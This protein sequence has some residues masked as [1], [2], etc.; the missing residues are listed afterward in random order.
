M[1]LKILITFYI[2]FVVALIAEVQSQVLNKDDTSIAWKEGYLDLHHINTGRGSVA[3]YIFPD[4]TTLLF[5]AGEQDP[6]DERTKSARN[7]IIR[8]NDKKRPFEWIA[9]YIKQVTPRNSNTVINYAILSHFHED[10]MGSWYE[11]A[12]KSSKGD[13]V[14]TGITGIAELLPIEVLLDRGYPSYNLPNDMKSSAFE[15]R[16]KANPGTLRYWKTMNNYFSFINYRE[17]QKLVNG[18][19]QAGSRTQV[20]LKYNRSRYRDF[21]VRNIKSNGRIWVGKDSGTVEH[22]TMFRR[23]DP[24]THPTENALSQVIT[25]TYGNFR[26]YTGGDIPGNINYGQPPWMD[27]E[28]PVAKAVGSVDVATMDHHGNRDALNE[29]MVKTLRPRV[30]IEQVWSSDHPGHEVL[31]RATTPYLYD[32]PRDLFATNMVQANKDVIGQLIDRSYKSLQGHILVRVLPG[33]ESYYVIIL[34][35]TLETL[36]VKNVFGPYEVKPKPDKD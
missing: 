1:Q 21:F 17:K 13:Y 3:Y 19:L 26:Y 30:W 33:G 29:F 36:K 24:A 9:N 10:H 16:L 5:D 8:P 28:T 14:L 6:T 2:T 20:Q 23:D 7:T 27:M 11:N 25:I 34:D 18:N 32:G 31:I 4:G 35:D 22:F 15:E 12:P